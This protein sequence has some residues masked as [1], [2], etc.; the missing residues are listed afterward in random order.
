MHTLVC[1]F[2]PW[3]VYAMWPAASGFFHLD[4]PTLMDCISV[5]P[6]DLS[7]R[8]NPFSFKQ[9]VSNH[10]VKATEEQQRHPV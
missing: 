3:T 7:I 9:P 10:V 4:L 5:S 8:V 6:Q 1:S 2:L